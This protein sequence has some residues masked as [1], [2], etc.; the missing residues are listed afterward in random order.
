MI[1]Y[2][3]LLKDIVGKIHAAGG[4]AYF[5]GGC[6]RDALLDRDC[7]DIDVEVFAL[8]PDT[9]T[10]ILSEFGEVYR[11]GDAFP[12][13]GLKE[14]PEVD[15][16]LPRTENKTGDKHTDF[17]VFVNPLLSTKAASQRRDFTVNALMYSPMK[18]IVVD[19]WGGLMDVELKRLQHIDDVKFSEDP[20]RVFRC[21]R[22]AATLNFSVA[23]ET[24][25]ICKNIDVTKL[26]RERVAA[27]MTK[28]LLYSEKP[29]LFFRVLHEMDKL[30]Y[31]MPELNA[32]VGV[33]QSKIHHP[34][35]DAFTHTM[36][37]VD[38]AAKWL[39]TQ[40]V[41]KPLPFMLS[42]LCHDLG[43]AVTTEI[44]EDGKITSIGHDA[45]G[46]PLTKKFIGRIYGQTNMMPYITNMV[47][48][49]MKLRHMAN[50]KS[51][52]KKTRKLFDSSVNP[53]DLCLLVY[54]DSR[55]RLTTEEAKS[56]G[57]WFIHDRLFDYNEWLKQPK[58]TAQQLIDL[59]Y[60]PGPQLGEMLKRAIHI[61]YGES[62]EKQ[63]LSILKKEFPKK[64]EK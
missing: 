5:V 64:I 45:A 39:K 3:D 37:V 50:N 34:E 33:K 53:N 61:S 8:N 26:S 36:M 20:L 35:G 17:K 2:D 27:E 6:V 22:F 38:E 10:Q 58:I 42:A 7:D 29:S 14:L 40:R 12:V 25:N 55:G 59:G 13:F 1:K 23:R 9:L 63:I 49:H 4:V 57:N 30:D 21:A 15:F 31:W 19:E 41:E 28:A 43:K 11:K 51:R 48:N 32:L 18:E 52:I 60:E 54:A 46:V 62:S 24:I 47:E 56:Q 44:R 16:S